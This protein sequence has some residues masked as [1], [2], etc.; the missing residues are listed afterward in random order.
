MCSSIIVTPR[1]LDEARARATSPHRPNSLSAEG[2][3]DVFISHASEDKDDL[4][5]PLAAALERRGLRV[6]YDESQ[7][8]VGDS[9]R[10]SIDRALAQSRFGVV[11]LSKSF[12]SKEWPNRELDGLIARA[13][14]R[15]VVL[16]V[17]HGLSYAELK[18]YSPTLADRVSVSSE[19]G[20]ENVADQICRAIMFGYP[21]PIVAVAEPGPTI[22][23]I[24]RA[25]LF[26]PSRHDLKRY[27]YEVE[28]YLSRHP[29]NV[30]ARMLK[31]VIEDA[32]HYELSEHRMHLPAVRT[33]RRSALFFL[34]LLSLISAIGLYSYLRPSTVPITI[35]ASPDGDRLTI[36]SAPK[37]DVLLC[38]SGKT[39]MISTCP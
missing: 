24:R 38:L 34:F 27:L 17:L 32:L 9:I 31:D 15:I 12:I 2:Y 1:R 28:K 18:E 21:H 4:A 3:F 23:S 30:D 16:P 10:R 39:T 6:W 35:A 19:M 25:I 29:D 8:A 11:L 22:D 13:D 37:T 5:R 36:T 14:G 33:R 7:L 20:V 26:G